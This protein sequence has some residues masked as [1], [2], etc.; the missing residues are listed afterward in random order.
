MLSSILAETFDIGPGI[1]QGLVIVGS[2]ITAV[3]G[4]KAASR[5]GKA[6]DAINGGEFD[7]TP[8]GGTILERL[9]SLQGDVKEALQRIS[10]LETAGNGQ[11]PK[12]T[13]PILG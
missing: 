5:A 6:A 12:S 4:A 7:H 3:F 1:L 13:P 8:E 10:A 11:A 2:A 9:D